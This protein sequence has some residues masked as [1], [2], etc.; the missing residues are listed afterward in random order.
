MSPRPQHHSDVRPGS[1]RALFLFLAAALFTAAGGCKSP[2]VKP[3]PE[4]ELPLQTFS[5]QWATDLQLKNDP[6]TSLHVRPNSVFAY[7]RSGRVASLSR[8]TGR[9]EYWVTI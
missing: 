4:R 6:L 2:P 9:I 1:G 8:E 5:R 3:A 7:T